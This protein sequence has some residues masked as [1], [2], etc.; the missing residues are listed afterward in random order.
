MGSRLVE[1]PA[2]LKRY[3]L[4][5]VIRKLTILVGSRETATG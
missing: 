1:C 3:A 4:D 2:E 5:M